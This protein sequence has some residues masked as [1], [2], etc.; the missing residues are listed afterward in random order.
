MNASTGLIK[1]VHPPED[2][3]TFTT[4]RLKFASFTLLIALG[5]A[6]AYTVLHEGGHALAGLAFG[7]RIGEVNLNFFN[8]GA[9][10]YIGGKFTRFQDAVI[11]IS[12]VGLP[13]L[14]WLMLI[15]TLPKNS[16]PLVLWTK[17]IASAGTL[18][19]LL[20]WVVIPFFYMI[21]EAP[22]GDDVTRFLAHS[23]LPPLSVAFV[24][25]AFFAG[26][27]F[28][29]VRRYAGMR[30]DWHGLFTGGGKSVQAWR[31]VLAGGV[32]A[33]ALIGAGMLLTSTLGDG[34][35]KPPKGFDL[36][37]TVDLSTRNVEAE[38]IAMFNLPR[39]GDV[40]IFIRVTGIDTHYFDVALAPSQGPS[41][42]LLHSEDVSIVAS[43][44]QKQYRLPA[45]DYGIVLTSRKS[46]GMLKVYFLFP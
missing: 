7:G 41:L 10:V 29:F 44:W 20:A 15:L 36:A 35:L 4:D 5:I 32:I 11:N 38:T 24:A 18:C 45:G 33:A 30:L 43:D 3:M 27:W 17:F 42:L 25:L 22:T 37:D 8:L 1:I 28:L 40:A 46:S 14:V 34:L 31:W 2:P 19:S 26:G 13:V 12:G 23:G 16:S 39:A 9:H 21:K 6:L